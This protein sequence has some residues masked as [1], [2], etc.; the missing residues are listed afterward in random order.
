MIHH[1][2]VAVRAR[3]G[4]ASQRN[5]DHSADTRADSRADAHDVRPFLRGFRVC[6]YAVL[7]R[8]GRTADEL[9][10]EGGRPR[11]H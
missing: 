1:R 5:G 6:T 9:Y 2:L 3:V 4:Q 8:P 7:I 10:R 11:A